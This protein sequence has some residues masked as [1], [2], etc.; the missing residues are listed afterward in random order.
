MNWFLIVDDTKFRKEFQHFMKQNTRHILYKA[1]AENALRSMESGFEV[2]SKYSGE[3]L[4]AVNSSNQV[5]VLK[6]KDIVHCQSSQNYT[7]F[8]MNGGKKLVATK[9]L[10][11]FE[12][13]LKHHRFVRVHQSHLV[14][15]NYVDKYV[16]GNGGYVILCDGTELPVAARKKEF[17]LREFEKL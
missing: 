11:Q 17:L 9:T 1:E 10:K 5:H 12:S 14:N 15:I 6:I 13:I 4:I 2:P 16:K 7:H 3:G 8:Q